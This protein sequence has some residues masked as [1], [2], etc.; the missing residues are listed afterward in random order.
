MAREIEETYK[1]RGSI[2][3]INDMKYGGEIIYCIVLAQR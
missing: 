2:G 1:K 3:V